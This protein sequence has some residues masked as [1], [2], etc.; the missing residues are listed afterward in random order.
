MSSLPVFL[1]KKLYVKRSLKNTSAGFEV[2]IQNTIAPGTIVGM[3]PL[4][5]DGDECPLE[6]T[7]VVLSD[8]TILTTADVCVQSPLR[9]GVGE[10]VTV[11]VDGQSLPPGQHKIIITPRTKEAGLLHIPAEDVVS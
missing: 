2:T 8:G 3:L 1:L 5:V 4:S 11:Q 7:R 6:R 9:F 10:R